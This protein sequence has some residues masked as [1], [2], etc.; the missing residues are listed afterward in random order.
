M[1]FVGREYYHN[2]NKLKLYYIKKRYIMKYITT[3][4]TKILLI[5][6]FFNQIG[7]YMI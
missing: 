4:T 5:F 6:K 2:I 7:F 3:N 1:D